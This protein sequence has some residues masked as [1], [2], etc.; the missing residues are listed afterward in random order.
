MQ[1]IRSTLV[2]SSLILIFS[3]CAHNAPSPERETLPAIAQEVPAPLPHPSTSEITGLPGSSVKGTAV[4]KNEGATVH[5]LVEFTGLAP[6]SKHGIHIHEN[7]S[8]GGAGFSGAGGH[9]NPSSI[10]H[11]G[12][13]S[14][15]RHAGDLGNLTSDANGYAKLDIRIPNGPE[16]DSFGGKSIILHAKADDLHSQPAGDSGARIACG[17]IKMQ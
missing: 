16:V 1:L 7:G 4:L 9:Y 2:A 10:Q 8:C 17:L 5:V 12:P 3:S 14:K 15:K 13:H 11:G 6:N